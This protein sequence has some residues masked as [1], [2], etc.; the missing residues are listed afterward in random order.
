[1]LSCL[2]MLDTVVASV[3]PKPAAGHCIGNHVP[4]DYHLHGTMMPTV[5]INFTV[6]GYRRVFEEFGIPSSLVGNLLLQ[7][8]G[9]CRQNH[10][11][12][13]DSQ[14]QT[15][16]SLPTTIMRLSHLKS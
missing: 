2:I 12:Q 7:V 10:S 3:I 4:E 14:L 9:N 8:I 13:M 16:S 6:G 1:M 15:L 5:L 11:R